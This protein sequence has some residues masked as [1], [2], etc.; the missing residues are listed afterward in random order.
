MTVY[1]IGL[2]NGKDIIDTFVTYLVARRVTLVV[3]FAFMLQ[4]F[5]KVAGTYKWYFVILWMQVEWWE[6]SRG[7]G[8]K[9]LKIILWG[10]GD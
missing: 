9:F 2:H 6:H 7:G 10:S 4:N 5:G 8:Y 1:I 3:S